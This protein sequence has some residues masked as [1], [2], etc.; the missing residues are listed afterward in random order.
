M[1]ALNELTQMLTLLPGIGPKSA[2]RIVSHLLKRSPELAGQLGMHFQHLHDRVTRCVQCFRFM[3]RGTNPRCTLC[4]QPTRSN[5]LLCVVAESSDADTIEA[6]H[7]FTGLYHVLGGL[8]DPLE[9]ITAEQLTVRAFID[10]INHN[11]P[12]EI[13]L[14][15]NEDMRGTTTAL[16]LQKLLSPMIAEGLVVSR[17]ARGLPKSAVIEYADSVTLSDALR[18]R[19]KI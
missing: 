10:R 5:A 9:G 14:A 6:T 3:D 16:Y 11:R 15:F 19:R 8:L 17:L 1:S 4:I 7:A 13:I 18:G 2:S 12:Q